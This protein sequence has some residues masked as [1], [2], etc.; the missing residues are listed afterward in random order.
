MYIAQFVEIKEEDM[1]TLRPDSPNFSSIPFLR[2]GRFLNSAQTMT[3]AD[4]GTIGAFSLG[5]NNSAYTKEV[6][7]HDNHHFDYYGTF[8]Y[9]GL[10]VDSD[11]SEWRE[12]FTRGMSAHGATRLYAGSGTSGYDTQLTEF[13]GIYIY[14]VIKEVA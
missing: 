12:D 13:N 8:R 5:Q 3:D 4:V 6:K 1:Q 7:A 10:S 11:G 9:S 14:S 2:P